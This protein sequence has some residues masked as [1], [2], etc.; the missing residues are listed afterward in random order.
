M[1]EITLHCSES[2]FVQ[3]LRH[4]STLLAKI[5]K[6][7]NFKDITHGNYDFKWLKTWSRIG[8][9]S[10]LDSFIR[11]SVYL[12]VVL[13]AMNMLNEQGSYWV[14]NTF[15]WNWLL[16]PILPLSDLIKQDIASSLQIEEKKPFWLKLTPYFTYTCITL[17]IW[18]ITIP[19]TFNYQN[20]LP[21]VFI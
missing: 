19:G 18:S 16:L 2:F 10:G 15:I 7:I 14:A 17:L 1:T 4:L 21:T 5:T 3:Y 13:R 9:F 12:V 20:I 6:K 8:F 11:N